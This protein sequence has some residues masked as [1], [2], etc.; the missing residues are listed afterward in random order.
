V[1]WGLL[2][3]DK[4]DRQLIYALHQVMTVEGVFG[5]ARNDRGYEG[6]KDQKQDHRCFEE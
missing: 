5:N 4:G 3:I 2:R 6:Y 1:S